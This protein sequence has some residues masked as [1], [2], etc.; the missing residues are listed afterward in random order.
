[1]EDSYSKFADHNVLLTAKTGQDSS[2]WNLPF[3]H[4]FIAERTVKC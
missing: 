3:L 2:F 4:P 1:M